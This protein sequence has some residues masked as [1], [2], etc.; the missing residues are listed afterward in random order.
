[1]ATLIIEVTAE[2]EGLL[3]TLPRG[4]GWEL[5]SEDYCE[6]GSGTITIDFDGDDL[7]AAAEQSLDTNDE[8]VSY[9]VLADNEEPHPTDEEI[10]EELRQLSDDTI[11]D[12]W[13]ETEQE[14]NH[15]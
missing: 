1:M 14:A 9:Q 12:D 7:S 6:D 5:Q 15:L 2:C 11:M 4:A 3:H 10:E 13:P 8:V